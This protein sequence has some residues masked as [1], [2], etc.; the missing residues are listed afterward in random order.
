MTR[1]LV[2]YQQTGDPHF[3]TFIRFHRAGAAGVAG[4]PSRSFVQQKRCHPE[5]SLSRFL[6]QT[7]SKD[8]RFHRRI[9]Q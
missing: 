8:L 6:R 7:E 4:V 3:L 9:L 2:R 1:A 5:R